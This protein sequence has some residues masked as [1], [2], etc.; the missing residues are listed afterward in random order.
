MD[1]STFLAAGV[2]HGQGVDTP[3]G[4]LPGVPGLVDGHGALAGD[5]TFG[6]ALSALAFVVIVAIGGFCVVCWLGPLA[7]MV[8]R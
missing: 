6:L 5:P 3:P 1:N 4:D 8:M 7:W 2:T